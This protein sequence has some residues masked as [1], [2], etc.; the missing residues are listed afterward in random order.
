[1]A[2]I[3]ITH[4]YET[5]TFAACTC[6]DV[7]KLSIECCSYEGATSSNHNIGTNNCK[8][9]IYVLTRNTVQTKR[10]NIYKYIT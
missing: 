4:I 2:H 6:S 10:I 7:T 8:H 9:I 5:T 1:M 3:D